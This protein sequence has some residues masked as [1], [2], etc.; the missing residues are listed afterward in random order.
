MRRESLICLALLVITLITFWP[1]GHLG[2]INYDDPG[3]DGYIVDQQC[4]HPGRDH[5]S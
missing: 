3:P 4:S 2:F 1:V 5:H